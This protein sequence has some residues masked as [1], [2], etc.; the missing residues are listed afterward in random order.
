MSPKK[1][2]QD[3]DVPPPMEERDEAVH[4]HHENGQTGIDFKVVLV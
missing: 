1:L 4:G 2:D 3:R